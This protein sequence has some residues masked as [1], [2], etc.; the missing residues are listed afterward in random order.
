MIGPL[1]MPSIGVATLRALCI[2]VCIGVYAAAV[3]GIG[4]VR[5]ILSPRFAL[6]PFGANG[7][8]SDHVYQH[9]DH[10]GL[11]YRRVV[12][13][14][15]TNGLEGRHF[16]PI[17]SVGRSLAT[18]FLA[19]NW[20]DIVKKPQTVLLAAKN[21]VNTQIAKSKKA[22]NPRATADRT[23]PERVLLVDGTG[24]AYRCF[25]ALPTLT[26]YRGTEI[27][28]IVGFMNSLG[29]IY[30]SFGPKYIGIA[31]DSPGSNSTKREVWPEY[32]ANRQ[33]IQTSFK[34]Q[35]MWIKEFCA[36]VGIPVFL[37]RATEAD[38]IIASMINF[39]SGGNATRNAMP[40]GEHDVQRMKHLDY[41]VPDSAPG[42]VFDR[43][44]AASGTP[45]EPLDTVGDNGMERR[46]FDVHVLTADKDLL[47][48]LEYNDG[49]N[50]R[51]RV[52]QPHK[53][54]RTVDEETVIEEYGIHP[55]RFSE[56]LALV[57]DSADNIP[58]VMGIGPKTAPVL[59]SK[60][61]SFKE[62]IESDE[63]AKIAKRG[64][65]Q[66][67]SVER[68]YDFHLITKLRG[69][70]PVLSSLS[71]LC[72]KKTLERQFVAFC[73]MFSLQKC[74]LRWHDVTH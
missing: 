60:Y 21:S 64:E 20:K 26:T 42:G 7:H 50:M 36:I 72:K 15:G 6:C 65:K 74:S 27:G 49:A 41:R 45:L 37:K 39:L 19:S 4:A 18:G 16:S 73:R 29:R 62:I 54:F 14:R 68:A 34:K 40:S 22:G 55:A 31:F 9:K 33:T 43:V 30:K 23:L 59:I 51:V 53:K 32:K 48:V 66:S 67:L 3:N 63:I 10:Y 56:Y 47:Q 8:S 28:A 57:G 2:W 13:I 52:I 44:S 38:D 35:L 24:L 70:V 17:R 25:F 58:G 69:D 71:D 1:P 46:S 61:A 11:L 5:D 12:A